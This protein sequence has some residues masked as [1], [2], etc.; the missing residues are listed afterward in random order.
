MLAPDHPEAVALSVEAERGTREEAERRAREEAEQRAREEAAQ[1]AR[2]EAERRARDEAAQ[3]AREE[4]EQ[5]ARDEAAQRAREEAE[6]RARDEAAQR[7]REE[8]EQRA[9][10]E[11]AQRAREEAERRARDK[12]AQRAREEAER[13][14]RDEAAQRAREEAERRAAIERRYSAAR[15]QLAAGRIQGAIDALVGLVEAEPEEVRARQLLDDARAQLADEEARARRLLEE[16]RELSRV[17]ALT[18]TV[19]KSPD[20]ATVFTLPVPADSASVRPTPAVIE[21][22]TLVEVTEP[23]PEA[24]ALPAPVPVSVGR[25]AFG[26]F[27]DPWPPPRAHRRGVVGRR[28]CNFLGDDRSGPVAS[29]PGRGRAGASARHG[30]PRGCHEGRG[31]PP[32]H[33]S[34]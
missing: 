5:R 32:R 17:A 14:A 30:R 6:Q 3:R 23:E 18:P 34:A 29:P 22:P 4:A 7:A 13:R 9:R 11:A 16:R 27:E 10:D 2:E 1:R 33:R 21:P 19:R 24:L 28:D 8:A 20:E 26:R 12:A 31:E 25:A 15:E